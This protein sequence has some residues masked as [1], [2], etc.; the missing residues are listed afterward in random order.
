MRL[1]WGLFHTLASS[2]GV[3]EAAW[4]AGPPQPFHQVCCQPGPDRH[5]QK[6]RFPQGTGQELPCPAQKSSPC[7]TA[8]CLHRQTPFA[9]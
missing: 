4:T 6:G 2:L 7:R 9:A 1:T 8:T 5:G 3:G